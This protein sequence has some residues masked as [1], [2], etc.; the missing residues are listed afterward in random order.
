ME[1]QS[2]S[3]IRAEYQPGE[4]VRFVHVLGGPLLVFTSVLH[5]VPQFLGNQRLVGMFHK[6]MLAFRCAEQLVVFIGQ[7]SD[8]QPFHVTEVGLVVQYPRDCTG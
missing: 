2:A 1:I 6:D 8:S 3:A 7:R 4:G 5:D